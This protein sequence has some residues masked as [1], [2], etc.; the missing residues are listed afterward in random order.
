MNINPERSERIAKLLANTS[1]DTVF[2]PISKLKRHQKLSEKNTNL[3]RSRSLLSNDEIASQGSLTSEFS[4]SSLGE[5]SL[6]E[7][8]RRM[9]EKIKEDQEDGSVDLSTSASL[10]AEI[11]SWNRRIPKRYNGHNHPP[12]NIIGC[13]QPAELIFARADERIRKQLHAKELKEKHLEELVNYIDHLIQ[14]KL[15]RGERYAAQLE[16]QQRHSSWLKVFCILRYASLVLPIIQSSKAQQT[17]NKQLAKAAKTIQTRMISWYERKILLRYANF[18]SQIVDVVW[19]FRLH[20]AIFQK[21]RACRIIRTFLQEK[22][23]NREVVQLV[24]SFIA[25][26]R[27]IQS[28]A[29]AFIACKMSRIRA[30]ATLW[31]DLETQYIQV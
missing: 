3:I 26:V 14:M 24:H 18:V 22:R 5:N 17:Q 20:V 8:I 10:P 9:E 13:H 6:R 2:I 31:D 28:T 27:K 7:K 21:R 12:V 1:T 30:L 15:T 4:L 11:F 29:R 16:Q 25:G 19:K 23:E